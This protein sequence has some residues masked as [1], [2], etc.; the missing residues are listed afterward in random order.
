MITTRYALLAGALALGF[1]FLTAPMAK[2]QAPAWQTALAVATTNGSQSYVQESA[3][4]ASGNVYVAG[5]FTGTVTLGNTALVSLTNYHTF[6]A[7]WSSATNTF[8]WAQALNGTEEQRLDAL[9]V[10]GSTVYLGGRFSGQLVVGSQTVISQGS[11]DMY[12]LK[13]TDAGPAAT[14]VWVQ[15][16]GGAGYDTCTGL[17][18]QGS[19]VYMSG[20][21]EAP[22]ATFGTMAVPLVSAPSGFVAKLV[23]AGNSSSF[24]WVQLLGTTKFNA[25][26]ALAVQGSS[27]YALATYAGTLSAGSIV[28][29]S[30]T[31]NTDNSTV[32]LLKFSDQGNSSLPVW[33][34]QLGGL[35][36]ATGLAIVA[37]GS[38]AYVAGYYNGSTFTAGTFT[39]TNNG[40]AQPFLAK[41][42]DTG[43][44]ST[45]N[46]V[47]TVSGL[48]SKYPRA[49]ALR[50]SSLYVAGEFSGSAQFGSTTLAPQGGSSVF[51]ARLL[52]AGSTASWAWATRA[53]SADDCIAYSLTLSGSRVV[54]G[55]SATGT[56]LFGNQTITAATTRNY[57]FLATLTD[58]TGLAAAAPTIAS[59]LLPYP[60][61]A[62]GRIS[63][64]VLPS[65]GTI[66]L[67][68]VDALGRSVR[69]QVVTPVAGANEVAFDLAGV[70]PGMYAMR[71]AAGGPVTTSQ[72][73]VE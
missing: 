43:T 5:I 12:V 30:P 70:A 58:A 29:N 68:L 26:N 39:L 15:R 9:A 33:G 21:I 8:T 47:Q 25:V 38:T 11:N 36:D 19:T 54:V 67:T 16:A 50:G 4:D 1:S 64:P 57:G 34:Q 53:G 7:K 31:N 32:G 46:W 24:G 37:S 56:A 59:T 48:G 3:A 40:G 49:L 62:H 73:V 65:A 23:D 13:L 17:A 61:P 14:V 20:Q 35:S 42:T 18:V 45:F 60:N 10:N 66:T 44:S 71:L 22:S 6:V 27:V 69:T 52:D 55:G 41:L 63:V 72:L 28:L 2:A 51:V